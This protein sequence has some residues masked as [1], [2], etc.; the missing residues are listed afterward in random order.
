M[1][2]TKIKKDQTQNFLKRLQKICMTRLNRKNTTKVI[3]TYAI[4]VVINNCGII[5]WTKTKLEKLQR[6]INILIKKGGR[7][8]IVITD[9]YNKQIAIIRTYFNNRI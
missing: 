2:H 6:R 8:I 3:N 1:D 7:E 9:L 4:P 5:E